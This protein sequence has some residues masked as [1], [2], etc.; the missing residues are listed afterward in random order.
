M[1][2]L[3]QLGA[4]WFAIVGTTSLIAQEQ[5]TFP[6]LNQTTRPLLTLAPDPSQVAAPELSTGNE[7]LAQCQQALGEQAGP[8]NTA[9]AAA[10]RSVVRG[11]LDMTRLARSLEVCR[12]DDLTVIQA[13]RVVVN[14]LN[15]HPEELRAPDTTLAL[16]ALQGAF[17]CQ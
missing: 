5:P 2:H 4:L 17:P 3:C 10:C 6:R 9:A 11:V 7:L 16:R 1:K 8:R 14:N 13:V 12:H 15:A